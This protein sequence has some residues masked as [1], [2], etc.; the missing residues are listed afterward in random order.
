MMYKKYPY[1][2]AILKESVEGCRAG[3]KVD[4]LEEKERTYTV[5]I[6]WNTPAFEIEKCKVELPNNK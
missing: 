4:I 2:S 3:T 1:P 5:R 6:Y